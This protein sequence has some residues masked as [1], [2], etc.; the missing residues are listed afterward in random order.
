MFPHNIAKAKVFVKKIVLR[1]D[2][3]IFNA[4]DS[5]SFTF[6]Y[7]R[8]VPEVSLFAKEIDTGNDISNNIT[9][10]DASI[11]AYVRFSK[12]VNENSLDDSKK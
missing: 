4:V 5:K 11:Y 9:T 1:T 2:M 3:V 12:R 6:I 7:D 10:N 8:T